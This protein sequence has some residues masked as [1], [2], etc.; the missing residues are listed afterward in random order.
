MDFLTKAW[1]VV[2]PGTIPTPSVPFWPELPV[3]CPMSSHVCP[4]F[5]ESIQRPFSIFNWGVIPF[6][7]DGPTG[8]ISPGSPFSPLPLFPMIKAQ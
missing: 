2:P 5:I 7:P 4:S 6:S 1:P 3:A 8:P